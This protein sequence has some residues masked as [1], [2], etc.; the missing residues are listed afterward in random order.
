VWRMSVFGPA[1]LLSVVPSTT[2]TPR[3]PPPPVALR[4]SSSATTLACRARSA[5]SST[6]AESAARC[7]G[8]EPPWPSTDSGGGGGGGAEDMGDD[9]D[10]D[11]VAHALWVSLVLRCT[12]REAV[13]HR[14]VQNVEEGGRDLAEVRAGASLPPSRR[15]VGTL[16]GGTV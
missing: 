13:V 11:D 8:P 1:M 2:T 7:E 15:K 10:D 4:S 6:D 16:W 3:D 5:L 9:D 14:R 12:S